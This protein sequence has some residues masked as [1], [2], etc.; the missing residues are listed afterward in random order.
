MEEICQAKF[1]NAIIFQC[2]ASQR[3]AIERRE[4]TCAEVLMEGTRAEMRNCGMC[5]LPC[6]KEKRDD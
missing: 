1:H 4:K 5:G 3:Y 6:V 2:C